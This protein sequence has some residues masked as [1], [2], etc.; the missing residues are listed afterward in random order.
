VSLVAI[1][2]SSLTG[3]YVF[4]ALLG[5]LSPTELTPAD[6]TVVAVPAGALMLVL[7]FTGGV[8]AASFGAKSFGGVLLGGALTA[9]FGGIL[10]KLGTIYYLFG[11]RVLAAGGVLL[12]LLFLFVS[13]LMLCRG[14]PAGRGRPRR[15]AT[16]L[17]ATSLA[18]ILVFFVLAPQLVRAAHYRLNI[19]S[20]PGYYDGGSN[21]IGATTLMRSQRDGSVGWL[22]DPHSAKRLL[23]FPALYG[24]AAFSEDGTRLAVANMAGP[25][26]TTSDHL[27]IELYD[28]QGHQLSESVSLR[29]LHTV[30]TGEL[31]WKD[32]RVL[33]TLMGKKRGLYEADFSTG[34]THKI[35]AFPPGRFRIA[36]TGDAH[37]LVLLREIQ[38]TTLLEKTIPSQENTSAEPH[39]GLFE[40]DIADRTLAS[41]PFFTDSGSISN[42]SRRLSPSG[43]YWLR[44]PTQAGGLLSVINL[45]TREETPLS[46]TPHIWSRAWL[47]NDCL[48]FFDDSAQE[49]RAPDSEQ[50][51]FIWSPGRAPKRLRG[52]APGGEGLLVAE[53]HGQRLLVM[54]HQRTKD[55]ATA[56]VTAE[57]YDPASD[58]WQALPLLS[59]GASAGI[60][61]WIGTG[62][63]GI[64]TDHKSC[65]VDLDHP[66][67]LRPL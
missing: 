62:I 56:V 29:A 22:V 60:A 58:D 9:I 12:T 44:T 64:E 40:I 27:R 19:L 3:W 48:A 5:G 6:D 18:L 57:V 32:G 33:F 41:E 17:V 16:V 35:V 52:F 63:V 67:R 13:W 28:A 7:L 47:P 53:P 36:T 15:G 14:E 11:V 42:A 39:L 59:E 10:A 45:T 55:Q 21:N 4:G 1:I 8:L 23:F 65:L 20:Y 46:R 31:L 34:S 61:N 50:S 49:P 51:L 66:D 26:L 30:A 25:L 54:M 2:G 38:A 37:R 43:R 24:G